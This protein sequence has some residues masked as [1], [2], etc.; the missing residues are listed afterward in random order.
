MTGT[1][2]ETSGAGPFPALEL[3]MAEFCAGRMSGMSKMDEA[4]LAGGFNR[5]KTFLGSSPGADLTN[6]FWP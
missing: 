1:D 6:Q 4:L 2:C 5:S 3:R